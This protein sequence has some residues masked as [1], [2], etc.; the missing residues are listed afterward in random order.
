MFFSRV[1]CTLKLLVSLVLLFSA[2]GCV[3]IPYPVPADVNYIENAKFTD[4]ALLTLGPRDLLADVAESI[5]ETDGNIVV[6]D[7]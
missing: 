4:D 7:G 6:V 5:T 3:Y 1:L 2:V